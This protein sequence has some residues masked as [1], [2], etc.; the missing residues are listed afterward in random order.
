MLAD[1]LTKLMRTEYLMTTLSKN[2]WCWTQTADARA[3]KER[4]QA[5]RRRSRDA[6]DENVDDQ[7][8]PTE[9]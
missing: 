5:Q 1:P 9:V 6:K 4:K 8:E 7:E 3:I 2:F